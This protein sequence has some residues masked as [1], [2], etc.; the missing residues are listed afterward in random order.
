MIELR[1]LSVNDGKDIYE[2]LQEM[3]R[4]ENG[5][6]N[7]VHGLTIE[8]FAAWLEA[9]Q[10]ESEQQGIRDGWKVPSTVYW[11]YVDGRPAGFGKLRHFLTDALRQAGGNIGYAIRPSM[12]GRGYGKELLHLLLEKARELGLDK[13]L[14]TVHK[15]NAASLAV[16]RANG[17]VVTGETDERYLVWMDT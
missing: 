10:R 2:M 9:M 1:R 17:G 8:E 7:K 12:R 15:D 16:I 11:L 14:V 13:A 3:P 4:E 6:E 5:F